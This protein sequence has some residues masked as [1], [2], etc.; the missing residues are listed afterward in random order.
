MPTCNI[1]NK[2]IGRHLSVV[3]QLYR[4]MM[5]VILQINDRTFR[6]VA[7]VERFRYFVAHVC[8][9]MSILDVHV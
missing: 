1:S 9:C 2:R 4:F 8:T 6:R 7:T 5:A 3:N